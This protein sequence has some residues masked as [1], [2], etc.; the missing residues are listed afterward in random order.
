MLS[1]LQFDPGVGTWDVWL[2]NALIMLGCTTVTCAPESSLSVS[3]CINGS[4]DK[5]VVLERICLTQKDLGRAL[6][7]HV[8]PLAAGDL[9]P[10]SWS[11]YDFM[12]FFILEVWSEAVF[13]DGVVWIGRGVPCL[14][15][16]SWFV[17]PGVRV[18][19]LEEQGESVLFS[20][21]Y[22]CAKSAAC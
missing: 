9:A 4:C 18:L 11:K 13:S 15:P 7:L 17:W 21:L 3:R 16:L 19:D 1:L 22:C 10:L 12:S 6:V 8:P 14:V 20:S 2:S 5:A